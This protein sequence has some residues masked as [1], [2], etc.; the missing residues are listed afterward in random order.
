MIVIGRTDELMAVGLGGVT[1]QP[2]GHGQSDSVLISLPDQQAVVASSSRHDFAWLAWKLAAN[3]R[4][5]LIGSPRH[6]V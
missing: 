1:H 4:T 3:L 2:A 6:E 5:V